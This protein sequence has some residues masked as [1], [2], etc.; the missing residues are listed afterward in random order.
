MYGREIAE[1][2]QEV[3]RERRGKRRRRGGMSS[4]R[5]ERKGMGK[6]GVLMR[7]KEGRLRKRRWREGEKTGEWRKK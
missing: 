1:E 3:G 5:R 7:D 2:E 4:E 6:E